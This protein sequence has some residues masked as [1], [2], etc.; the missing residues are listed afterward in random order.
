M[1]VK[2][3]YLKG[4][5]KSE[6]QRLVKE[7]I[8]QGLKDVTLKDLLKDSQLS[9]M[10]FANRQYAEISRITGLSLLVLRA[11]IKVQDKESELVKDLPLSKAEEIIRQNAPKVSIEYDEANLYG[12]PLQKF[13]QD[14]IRDNVSPVYDRLAKQYPFDPASVPQGKSVFYEEVKHINS[15]RNRAEIE[16]RYND[17]Q[18]N[19]AQLKEAGNKLVIASNHAD[20]SDRCKE[21]QGRV[22]SL[23]HTSGTTPDGRKY[24]PLETATDVYYTTRAG[25]VWKNGLL[26]FNCRHYLVAYKDGLRF[27]KP[28]PKIEAREYKITE[29]Q[30][31]LERNVRH[32][33]TRAI[34]E[35]G[36]NKQAYEY[37]KRKAKAWNKKYIDFSKQNGRA[38]YPSRTKVL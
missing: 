24:I 27:P 8:K 12:V 11:C 13:S 10:D 23:D 21:W 35:K 6:I 17:H 19:I 25:K 30:R 29:K 3:E 32:W 15:L 31:Q 37:A 5:P 18:D 20:C 16:V 1:I 14:Y 7:A 28:N 33:R 26:G 34:Y 2:N 38:Y 9:L 4:T 36:T 22:Y